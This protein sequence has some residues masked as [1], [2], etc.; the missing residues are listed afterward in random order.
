MGLHSEGKVFGDTPDPGQ[1]E[2]PRHRLLSAACFCEA[3][4]FCSATQAFCHTR[5][6]RCTS[7]WAAGISTSASC[8][9]NMGKGYLNYDYDYD[10]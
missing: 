8:S 4:T 2:D 5:Q 9:G 1:N 10:T 7:G 6:H 3:E